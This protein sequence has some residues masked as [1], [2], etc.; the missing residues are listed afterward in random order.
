LENCWNEINA[1]YGSINVT[2]RGDSGPWATIE[3]VTI[4]N[5]VIKHVG[6]GINILGKDGYQPS[7]RGNGV[8]IVNN[9][10][11]DLNGP[12]WSEDGIFVKISDMPGVTI[13]HNTVFNTGSDVVVYGPVSENF[14]FTNNI[15]PHNSYGIIGQSQSS[16]KGTIETY[17]PD[18][19]FRRNLI[20]GASPGYPNYY[21]ADNFY[22]TTIDQAGFNDFAAGDYG[23]GPA[24][25]YKRQGTDGKD[26]GC[27]FA[28]LAA[29]SAAAISG[30]PVTP[31]PTPTPT[32]A[33]TPAP[34]PTPTPAPTPT[35]TP[36][37]TPAPTPAPTPTPMPVATPTPTPTPV[38]TPTPTPVITPTPTPTPVA[39]PTP[40][41]RKAQSSL[42]KARQDAQNVSNA[43]A[44]TASGAADPSTSAATASPADRIAAVVLDIQQTY[45][46][47]SNE[48]ALYAASTRIEG[49]LSGALTYAAAAG[50]YAGQGQMSEAKASLQKAIDNMELADVLMT[51]GDV[52]NP[53]DYSQYFVRQH[54]VDFLGREPDEAGRAFWQAEIDRCGTDA[55][56]VE[57]K[58]INVSAAYFF[59]IE[60][61]QTGFLV[62]RLYQ[63][64]FGRMVRLR[65]FLA[66]SQEVSK[67]VIVGNPSWQDKLAENRT[68][69]FQS[70]VQR[71]DFRAR[72]DAL[73]APQF[74]DSLY[75][76]MGVVPQAAERDPLVA[77]LQTGT[78][79]RADVLSKVVE[80]ADFGRLERN[81]AFVLMQYFGYLRRDPDDAGYNFWLAKLE[82]FNGDF[83]RAEM[84]KAF[85]S[86]DEYRDRFRQQ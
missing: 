82:Q 34:T 43:L 3:D 26:I 57:V 39:S 15:A 56:C 58:R 73:S 45:V 64:S 22:P 62:C 35:P 2:V 85:L 46:E 52:Q 44:N 61:Q 48:H 41:V 23:L 86:S 49:A 1:G 33:P 70:W 38:I 77:S 31:A 8:R 80:N 18:G 20:A 84:V 9:L 51:Y 67:G 21:P 32:P 13:D 63:A 16:G 29:S 68:A 74:V 11:I 76:S 19:L 59:S 50:S 40:L 5:N 7:V 71:P 24:S 55:H 47:F 54:Y 42:V 75:A 65:E 79:T 83:V 37:P 72:Y 81:R 12:R 30:A 25:P 53:V 69:F 17:F 6:F 10:F 14:V 4:A 66:D 60:F 78:A 28:L 36:V 27:D